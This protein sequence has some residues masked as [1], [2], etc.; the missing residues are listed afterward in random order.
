MRVLTKICG[1]TTREGLDAA[2]AAGADMLGFVFAESPR[3][4]TPAQAERLAR[5]IPAGVRRV[6]VFRDADAALLAEVLAVFRPDFVQAD[7]ASLAGRE[8]GDGTRVLPVFR[9]GE[10]T[11]AAR[12][13]LMLYES[14]ESGRGVRA[15]WAAAARLASARR[16]ILAGGLSPDN[17]ADA[18]REVRPFGV[19]VSSGVEASRGVKS[20][21]L[22][23]AFVA[24]VR[25]AEQQISPTL[26]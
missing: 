16:L 17:V 22:I 26:E 15:D 14:A 20:P 7:A 11:M 10:E 18:V 23:H 25:A 12:E 19:D 4:V 24:A 1:L 9:D 5:R 8:L 6:A 13:P 21:A 2:L 3:R